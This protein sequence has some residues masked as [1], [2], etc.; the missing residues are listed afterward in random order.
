[1]FKELIK[2]AFILMVVT[3][4]ASGTLALVHSI[5]AE[6]IE[7]E[8]RK[9]LRQGLSYVLPGSLNGVIITVESDNYIYY[10]GYANRDTTQLIEYAFSSFAKGY[11]STIWTLVG[12][13]T[14]GSISRIKI[15]DQKET[16]GLGTRCTEIKS[17]E[18]EAW[19]EVQFQGK[20]VRTVSVDKDDG[21]IIS[22]T[23]ATITSRAIT[24]S[25]A[26][27]ATTLLNHLKSQE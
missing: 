17:G 2:Y 20:D 4:T 19:W 23:G 14:T 18:N 21:N 24:N 9:E 3:L 5:T 25:I 7:F 27:Q 13:D 8:K 1:M 16:P 11:S 6:K 10:E 26:E 15:L 12:L 22:I